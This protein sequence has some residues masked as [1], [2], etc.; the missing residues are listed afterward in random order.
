MASWRRQPPSCT[1]RDVGS[2]ES[3][4]RRLQQA[5]AGLAGRMSSEA[6]GSGRHLRQRS[7][8]SGVG[9]SGPGPGLELHS[10]GPAG[11]AQSTCFWPLLP[12]GTPQQL[13]LSR[14]DSSIG[15]GFC[16]LLRGTECSRAHTEP[17]SAP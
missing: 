14:L 17:S 12:D 6:G 9:P 16:A 3:G 8:S 7:P 5:G 1:L 11:R 15:A 10:K 4:E 2:P 13:V